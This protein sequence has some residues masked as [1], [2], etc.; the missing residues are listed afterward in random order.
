MKYCLAAVRASLGEVGEHT[1]GAVRLLE[2]A[3]MRFLNHLDPFDAGPYYGAQV[4]D[5]IPV[6]E[7]R[8]LRAATGRPDR[9]RSRFFLVGCD[10]SRG[11]RAVRADAAVE[12]RRLVVA[13]EALEVLGVTEGQ[14]VDALALP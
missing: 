2:R 13:R 9:A 7:C 8:R 3:G 4:D 5:L 10:D 1:R 14:Q 12:G 6:R 11:F